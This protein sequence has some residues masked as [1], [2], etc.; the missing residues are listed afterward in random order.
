MQLLSDA[1][2]FRTPLFPPDFPTQN[3]PRKQSKAAAASVETAA[4]TRTCCAIDFNL[5][6]SGELFI[7]SELSSRGV[8]LIFGSSVVLLILSITSVVAIFIVIVLGWLFIDVVL[9][10]LFIDTVLGLLGDIRELRRVMAGRSF[11]CRR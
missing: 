6:F 4:T 9:G 10:W 1:N 5:Q 3:P 11:G 7:G 8:F 2:V